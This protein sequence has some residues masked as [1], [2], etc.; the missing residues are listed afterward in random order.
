MAVPNK[1]GRIPT[2]TGLH[3]QSRIKVELFHTQE[4][5]RLCVSPA[6]DK[7]VSRWISTMKSQSRGTLYIP[8]APV[9]DADAI[10][11]RFIGKVALEVLAKRCI[12]VT[13]WN[14]EIVDKQELNDLRQYV[15]VGLPKLNWPV[16]IR[17]IYPADFVF[18]DE[19]HGANQV[20]HEWTIL[21]VSESGYLAEY[22]AIIAIFGIEYAINLGGPELEGYDLWLKDNEN[23]SP[24]YSTPPP[25]SL[26]P[27]GNTSSLK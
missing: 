13:G 23:R 17:R 5:G 22:Y 9:P 10:T 21:C 1:K 12:D 2:V 19:M 27:G 20:L 14:D 6:D 16:R 18:S 8:T 11:A 15:R 7:D 24:L 3:A 4:D 26:E 25:L